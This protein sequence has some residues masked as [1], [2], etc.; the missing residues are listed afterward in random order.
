MGTERL[1]ILPP[2]MVSLFIEEQEG[3]EEEVDKEENGWVRDH[4]K[5]KQ[6][7]GL[8][9]VLPVVMEEM[10]E[11]SISRL[12]WKEIREIGRKRNGQVLQVMEEEEEMSLLLPLQYKNHNK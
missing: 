11:D 9:G 3:A 1:S 6:S 10:G 8:G 4:L 2:G 7:K 5:E 12:L